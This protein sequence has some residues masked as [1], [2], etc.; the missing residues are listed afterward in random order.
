M[1]ACTPTRRPLMMPPRGRCLTP[2]ASPTYLG[3]QDVLDQQA[4]L[5]LIRRQ[6]HKTTFLGATKDRDRIAVW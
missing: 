2:L 6:Q 4:W 3:A 5:V 1:R